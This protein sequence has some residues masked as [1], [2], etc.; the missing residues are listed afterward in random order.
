M[1]QFHNA[2][3]LDPKNV[4]TIAN[5]EGI[6]R[7]MGRNPSNFE[8]RVDLGNLA[9][10]TNDIAGGIIEYKAALEIQD[11]PQVKAKLDKLTRRIDR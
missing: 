8:D 10:L 6:I 9:V 11:D 4:T 2:V 1:K 7:I 3:Y 5:M